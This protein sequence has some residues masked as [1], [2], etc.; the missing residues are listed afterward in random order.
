MGV[1][2]PLLVA[3]FND[4]KKLD[5]VSFDAWAAVLASLPHAALWLIRMLPYPGPEE[6]LRKHLAQRGVGAERIVVTN[7]IA[8]EIHL[9]QKRQ[10]VDLF[11][12]SFLYNAHRCEVNVSLTTFKTSFGCSIFQFLATVNDLRTNI[13][14]IDKFKELKISK[15]SVT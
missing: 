1:A 12:D 4:W 6:A 11:V 3:N 14:Y 15:V 10:Q 8:A 7:M 9:V 5:P 13:W 2:E